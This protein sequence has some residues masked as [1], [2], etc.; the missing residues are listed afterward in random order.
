[1]PVSAGASGAGVGAGGASATSLFT[2]VGVG[3]G[4]VLVAVGLIFVLAYLNVLN[5]SER[6]VERLR[7]LCV[8]VAI[9]LSVTF[10]AIVIFETLAVL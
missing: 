3:A 8:A 9:P 4:G 10:G 2:A 7:V 5:A 6:D 1:M